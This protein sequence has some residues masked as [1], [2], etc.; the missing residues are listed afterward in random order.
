[1]I[2][3]AKFGRSPW[4][5]AMVPS[6]GQPSIDFLLGRGHPTNAQQV[7]GKKAAGNSAYSAYSFKGALKCAQFDQE[8][9]NSGTVTTVTT[10]LQKSEYLLMD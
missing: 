7:W 6:A 3:H 2:S 1:M 9:C 4:L 10:G 5:V 8:D